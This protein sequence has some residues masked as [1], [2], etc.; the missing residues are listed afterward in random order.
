MPELAECIIAGL[1]NWQDYQACTVVVG[2]VGDIVR[3][4]D[5][6]ILPYCDEIVRS[7]LDNLQNRSLDR[8]VKPNILSCFG[9]IAISIKQDFNRYIQYVLEVLGNAS[10][11]VTTTQIDPSDTDFVDYINNFCSGILDAYTGIIHGLMDCGNQQAVET[12][13]TPVIN[14]V[15]YISQQRTSTDSLKKNCTRYC[16]GYYPI[17]RR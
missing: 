11:T 16:W 13:V 12:F 3:A 15:I 14:L 6:K 7:L 2:A 4:I 1:K 9:D 8:S 17:S 10:E 5:I